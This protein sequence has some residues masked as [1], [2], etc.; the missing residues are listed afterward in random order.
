[1]GTRLQELR[2]FW[3]GDAEMFA[4]ELIGRKA[5]VETLLVLAKSLRS[6]SISAQPG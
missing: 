2:G 5:L 1:L 3:I 6:H 4:K